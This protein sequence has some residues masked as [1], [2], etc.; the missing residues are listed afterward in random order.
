[1]DGWTWH[2]S[3]EQDPLLCTDVTRLKGS[4]VFAQAQVRGTQIPSPGLCLDQRK[5]TGALPTTPQC[6]PAS[7][8]EGSGLT[9][10][11]ASAPRSTCP[12]GQHQGEL[13]PVCSFPEPQ[14]RSV[15]SPNSWVALAGGCLV[16]GG[17]LGR[18]SDGEF[19]QAGR[20]GCP[21][22]LPAGSPTQIPGPG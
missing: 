11:M 13:E 3:L 15:S 20:P 9:G 16:W 8:L 22:P 14:G 10:R 4:C 21:E 1:M 2:R 5:V 12:G 6:T 18:T 19:G 17:A 7:P